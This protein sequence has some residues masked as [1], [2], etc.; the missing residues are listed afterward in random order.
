MFPVDPDL[1]ALSVKWIL[2]VEL[3]LS[4]HT[5]PVDPNL[6]L[7]DKFSVKWLLGAGMAIGVVDSEPRQLDRLEEISFSCAFLFVELAWQVP[8]PPL[9]EWDLWRPG[10]LC[11]TAEVVVAPLWSDNSLWGIVRLAHF[12]VWRLEESSFLTCIR[13]FPNIFSPLPSPPSPQ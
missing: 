10:V 9:N 12:S 1:R 2:A 7:V 11:F 5:F 13:S 3:C 8:V 6:L 4:D